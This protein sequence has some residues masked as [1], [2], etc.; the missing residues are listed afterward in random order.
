MLQI[1]T[2]IRE[3]I[4]FLRHWLPQ[5]RLLY[6]KPLLEARECALI[7]HFVNDMAALELIHQQHRGAI[8]I[9]ESL[10]DYHPLKQD[11]RKI[12]NL[13]RTCMSDSVHSVHSVPTTKHRLS[14]PTPTNPKR[15]KQA[16]RHRKRACES[17]AMTDLQSVLS[18]LVLKDE[19][20]G[21]K[22]RKI[23]KKHA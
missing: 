20:E 8:N 22:S 1:S 11:L 23:S 9:Q 15:R 16:P 12:V 17:E 2:T 5:I 7:N 18:A 4:T 6:L 3:K 14:T 10:R 19:T 21:L 13:Q